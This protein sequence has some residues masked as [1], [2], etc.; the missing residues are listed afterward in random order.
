MALRGRFTE[1]PSVASDFHVFL[2]HAVRSVPNDRCSAHRVAKS[3][4][5]LGIEMGLRWTCSE[6]FPGRRIMD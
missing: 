1:R 5:K 4:M 3:Q 6:Q 2:E